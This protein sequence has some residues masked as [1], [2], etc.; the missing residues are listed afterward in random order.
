MFLVKLKEKNVG[1]KPVV[2]VV[3]LK[4]ESLPK[5]K[6]PLRLFNVLVRPGIS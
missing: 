3:V 6:I 2:N 1:P 4:K 5:V